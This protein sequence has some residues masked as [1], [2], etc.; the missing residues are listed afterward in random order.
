[1]YQLR[2]GI[3]KNIL[4]ETRP[5]TLLT[6]QYD[7]YHIS[8]KRRK[9][10]DQIQYDLLKKC[11][12]EM[13]FAEWNEWYENYLQ[14]NKFLRSTD[15]YGAKLDGA[16]LAYC[17][18]EGANL[19]FAHLVNADLSYTYLRQANLENANLAGANLWRAYFVG[20]KLS[21]ANP[22][23]ANYDS[24]DKMKYSPDTANF[25]KRAASLK[26]ISEWNAWYEN[27]LADEVHDARVYGAFLE[28]A[29]LRNLDLSFAVLRYAH[30]EGSDLRGVVLRGADLSYAHLEGAD[31]WDADLTDADLSH[32]ELG[33]AN[34]SGAKM[35]GVKF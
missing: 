13:N 32:A 29:D 30:L 18:L 31:L 19:S 16:D 1:M 14:E 3:F 26:N 23:A 21:G 7:E 22:D 35:E 2:S 12:A 6:K 5:I 4:I 17:Y 33:G 28:E 10:F 8:P 24:G 15:N 11:S 25:L 20:A 27:E 34:L 9:K